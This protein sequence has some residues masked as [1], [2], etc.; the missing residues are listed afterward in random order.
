MR[1]RRSAS[2]L[3]DPALE[4]A[5]RPICV[6]S[7]R[8]AL[9]ETRR[10]FDGLRFLHRTVPSTGLTTHAITMP[11]AE[12]LAF[13]STDRANRSSSR[14]ILQFLDQ[15]WASTPRS[16]RRTA[17]GQYRALGRAALR[18]LRSA[19]RMGARTERRTA[20]SSSYAST[21]HRV[22]ATCETKSKRPTSF[23]PPAPS[24]H[25]IHELYFSL[26]SSRAST[27]STCCCS[28]CP[29]CGRR[30]SCCWS[31]R[32]SSTEHGTSDFWAYCGSPR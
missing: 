27:R 16:S 17:R 3:D 31:H 12:L 23:K 24:S 26:S 6:R 18:T 32:T 19:R 7:N 30:T 28:A 1:L 4:A 14:K 21:S 22:G 5:R 20:V 9:T 29:V 10:C 2:P 15:P 11:T 25:D 8:C 13:R